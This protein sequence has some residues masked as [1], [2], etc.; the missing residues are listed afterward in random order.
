KPEAPTDPSA[1]AQLD[2][3]CLG[4]VDGANPVIALEPAAPGKVVGV[5]PEGKEVRKDDELLW[6]NDEAARLRV[7]EAQAAVDTAAAEVQAADQEAATFEDRKQLAAAAVRAATA[8]RKA[9]EE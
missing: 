4:R 7:A 3:V 6:L 1:L 5:V 9:A 2:V 8:R